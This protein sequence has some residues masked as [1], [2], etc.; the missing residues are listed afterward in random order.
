MDDPVLDVPVLDVPAP[1]S[2]WL[3]DAELAD[4]EAG[5]TAGLDAVAIRV[6]CE[7]PSAPGCGV[8]EPAVP[9]CAGDSAAGPSIPSGTEPV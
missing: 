2:I 4:A 7:D 5:C 1:A 6:A 8:T 3:D 9:V